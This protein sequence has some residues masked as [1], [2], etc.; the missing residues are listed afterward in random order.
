MKRIRA[1]KFLLYALQSAKPKLFK[2][3]IENSDRG[4][5]LAICEIIYNVLRGNVRLNNRTKN[6]LKRYKK[7]L[8]CIACP[9]QSISSKRRI[10]KQKGGGVILPLIIGSVLSGLVSSL[11]DKFLNNK[12]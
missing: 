10:I 1:N 9:K 12:K 2:S 3:I 6:K 7:V 11:G 5:I 4:L 8:R